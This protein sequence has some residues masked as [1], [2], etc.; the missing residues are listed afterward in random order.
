MLT[1][2]ILIPLIGVLILLP[3]NENSANS[4]QIIK[5]L[6]LSVS[7]INLFISILI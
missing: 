7:L 2:L 3:F 1:L 5:Q 4:K 6:A